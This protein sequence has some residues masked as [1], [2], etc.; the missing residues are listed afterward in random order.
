MQYLKL[1]SGKIIIELHN[2]WLGEETVIVGGQIVSKKSSVYGVHHF[3]TVQEDGKPVNFVL[4]TKI[5]DSLMNVAVDV[6]R[7]GNIIHEN[8]KLPYGSKPKSASH[9][10]KSLGL[11]KLK[12][13]DMPEAMEAFMAA[14]ELDPDDAEVYF[15]LACVYSNMEDIKNGYESLKKAVELG[16]SNQESILNHDMLAFLRIQSEFEEFQSSGY[17]VIKKKKP[18]S[19]S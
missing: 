9:E 7:N 10:L 16:L 1:R 2:N 15:H 19:T 11:S 13:Y 5:L 4:T 18:K 6:T 17:K 14:K 12:N 8:V 3:F